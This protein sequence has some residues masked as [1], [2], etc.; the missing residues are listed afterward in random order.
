[1]ENVTEQDYKRVYLDLVEKQRHAEDQA[2]FWAAKAKAFREAAERMSDVYDEVAE[3]DDRA[4]STFVQ[5]PKGITRVVS[6]PDESGPRA[7]DIAV[8][9]LE[10]E[11]RGLSTPKLVELMTDAG[12]TTE[13]NDKVNA[14][15]TTLHR[16]SIRERGRVA[17]KGKLWVLRKWEREKAEPQ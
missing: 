12:W 9:C 1:M 3:L 8:A 5:G 2:A 15:Y 16:D 13:A 7:I 14:A 17:R 11:N 4:D 10:Q 6:Q